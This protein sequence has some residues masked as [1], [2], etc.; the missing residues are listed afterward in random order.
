MNKSLLDTDTLSEINKGRDQQV[1]ANASAYLTAYPCFTFSVVT[2]MEVVRGYYLA[3]QSQR[4]SQFLAGLTGDE[5]LSFQQS[6]AELAGKIDADL[7]ASGQ[8]IG[9]A[10]PMIAATAIEHGLVLVT[11]NTSHYNRI[12]ALG[13][14]LVLDNWRTSPTQDAP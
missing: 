10:D 3:K 12:Q 5:I 9:R 13:Y 6:T 1:L 2:V 8:P 11:G 7:V 14:P 4:L